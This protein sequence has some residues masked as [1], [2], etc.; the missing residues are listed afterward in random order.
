MIKTVRNIDPE[1][2]LFK[3][4]IYMSYYIDTFKFVFKLIFMELV[5]TKFNMKPVIKQHAQA[6]AREYPLSTKK[7]KF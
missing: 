6:F 1:L 3:P 5:S 7:V 2:K 4:Y